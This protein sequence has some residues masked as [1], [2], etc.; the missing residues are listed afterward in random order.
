MKCCS[1][2]RISRSLSAWVSSM[3]ADKQMFVLWVALM[4]VVPTVL[5]LF[6]GVGCW[7]LNVR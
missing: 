2:S 4:Y 7:L 3:D 6:V 5:L 1:L